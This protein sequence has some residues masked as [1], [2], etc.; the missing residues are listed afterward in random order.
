MVI[1]LA[2]P[3]AH[4]RDFGSSGFIQRTM[5]RTFTCLLLGV[6][7]AGCGRRAATIQK[8]LTGTWTRHWGLGFSI[9]NVIAPD[10]NYESWLFNPTTGTTHTLQGRMIAK[11]SIL[12][13]TVTNDSGTN[14]QT[15]R[16]VQWQIEHIDSNELVIIS[17]ILADRPATVVTFEKVE[18]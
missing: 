13:D 15:P 7:L 11:H 9:T 2:E 17:K 6:L 16:V 14:L 5:K 4:R 8:E 3:L 1:E 10:G 18:R 12:I